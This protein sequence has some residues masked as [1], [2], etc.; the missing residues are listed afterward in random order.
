MQYALIVELFYE[1]PFTGFKKHVSKTYVSKLARVKDG[2]VRLRSPQAKYLKSFL[3]CEKQ[4][5]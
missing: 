4:K 5:D 3:F 2:A 1:T